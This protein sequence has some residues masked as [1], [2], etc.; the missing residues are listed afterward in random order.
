MTSR[1]LGGCALE[2]K[3]EFR[4]EF[5]TE[6]L[7]RQIEFHVA[8]G[9]R[10]L[11]AMTLSTRSKNLPGGGPRILARLTLQGLSSNQRARSTISRSSAQ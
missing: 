4:F 9:I 5:A 7:A 8:N 3:G 10:G 6:E 11:D 2:L 1:Q